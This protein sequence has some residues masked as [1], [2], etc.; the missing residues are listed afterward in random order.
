MDNRKTFIPLSILLPLLSA[1]FIVIVGGGLGVIF[2][3]LYSTYL[4]EWGVIMLGMVFVVGV[5]VVA[6]IIA[7]KYEKD[8]N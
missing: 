3:I 4:H 6:A 8:V 1:L 7:K 2:M 5:P